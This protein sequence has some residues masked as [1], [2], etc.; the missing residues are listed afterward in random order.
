ME[1]VYD[2]AKLAFIMLAQE[3]V[4]DL[5][6]GCSK[7]RGTLTIG[8][9]ATDRGVL[10]CDSRCCIYNETTGEIIEIC[11]V[12]SPVEGGVRQEEINEDFVV[13][14]CGPIFFARKILKEVDKMLK[15][16]RNCELVV[17]FNYLDFALKTKYNEMLESENAYLVRRVKTIQ[18][19]VV[20][21]DQGELIMKIYGYLESSNGLDELDVE[22]FQ[23]SGSGGALATP[24][25]DSKWNPERSAEEMVDIHQSAMLAVNAE[26]NDVGGIHRV[27]VVRVNDEGRLVT[28][29]S[30]L[31]IGQL[32]RVEL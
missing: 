30:D 18:F 19:I 25:I 8:S 13:V 15:C 28:E 9:R 16:R 10:S 31:E 26:R 12:P 1:P 32:F 27:I 11:T 21:V 7:W 22:K 23:C 29:S 5:S 14:F 24:I 20:E 6:T 4:K 3:K 2:R 17:D